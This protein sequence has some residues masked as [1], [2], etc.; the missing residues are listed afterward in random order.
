MGMALVCLAVPM[1]CVAHTVN[2]AA[3]VTVTLRVE[4]ATHT[5]FDGPSS[6]APGTLDGGD[7][8]GLHPCGGE[9]SGV[10]QPTA[11]GALSSVGLGWQGDWFSEFGDFFVERIGPDASQP[12]FAYWALLVNWRY[13][14]GACRT[15][16]H[17]GDEVLWAYDTAQRYV[18]ALGAGA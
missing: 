16:L 3:T 2:A 11:V 10:P 13:A 15:A 9:R 6:V 12:P 4:G 18:D 7:G 14:L 17:D 1:L 5:L 8:S